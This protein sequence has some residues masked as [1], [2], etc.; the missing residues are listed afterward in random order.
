MRTYFLQ[1]RPFPN[2]SGHKAMDMVGDS[3][4]LR[5]SKLRKASR[6]EAQIA[7]PSS[8]RP[9]LDFDTTA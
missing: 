7:S 4:P 2:M 8:S 1:P 5:R 9:I 6:R 3:V